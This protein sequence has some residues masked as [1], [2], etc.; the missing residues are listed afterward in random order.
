M[1]DVI[2]KQFA[3]LRA[4]PQL[5]R[6]AR[7]D[8]ILSQGSSSNDGRASTAAQKVLVEIDHEMRPVTSLCFDLG[9]KRAL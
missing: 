9:E 7:L 6:T 1:Q 2:N 4:R 5:Q 8:Q 3:E